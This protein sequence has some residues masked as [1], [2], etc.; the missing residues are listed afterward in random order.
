MNDITKRIL[1]NVKKALEEKLVRNED[2][3]ISI[4]ED[5]IV[6]DGGFGNIV[7]EDPE[8]NRL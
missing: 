4:R 3:S 2:G 7:N 8:M 6:D 5:S 1:E